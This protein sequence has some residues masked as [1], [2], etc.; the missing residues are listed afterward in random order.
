[1]FH[2]A[3]YFLSFFIL[4][5]INLKNYQLEKVFNK[6]N[7]NVSFRFHLNLKNGDFCLI[8]KGWVFNKLG[9]IVVVNWMIIMK[10]IQMF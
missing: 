6:S 8:M 4:D 9:L 7:M 3:N 10:R 5:Q 2:I 1:M